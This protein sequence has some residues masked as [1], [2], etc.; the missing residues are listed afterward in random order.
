MTPLGLPTPQDVHAAYQ[1]GEEAVLVQFSELIFLIQNLQ[2]RVSALEDQLG[3]NSRNSSKPPSSDG[4]NKPRPRSLRTKSGKKSG[5]QPGHQGH[6]LKAV[7]QPDHVVIHPVRDCGQCG[8]SLDDIA[9]SA[10]EPRQVF[11]LPPVRVE[12]TEHRGEIKRCPCC[13][14]S[15]KAEFPS[16]VTQPVQY[17]P[18][19]KS[20]AVYL[21]QYQF[22]PLQRTKEIFSDLYGHGV[23]ESTIVRAT[24]EMTEC[25]RPV[26]EKVKAQLTEGEPVVHFD[27]SGLRVSGKL[28]W[29]HSA[30]TEQLTYYAVHSKRGCEAIDAIGILPKLKGRAVHD[31]WRSYFKYCEVSHSLCNAHHLRELDFIQERYEQDWAEEMTD[32]LLEIKGEVDEARPVKD[33]LDG[34]QVSE[35]EFR[36]D[37]LIEEGLK[38]NPPPVIAEDQ[39][40]KRGRV[41]QSPPKNLLDR[42]LAHKQEVLAFM[43]DFKVPFDNNQAERDIRMV[44]LKQKVSGCFRSQ[45]GAERFCEVRSYISTARKNGQPVLGAL[46]AALSG[47]PFVPALLLSG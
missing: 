20:Q 9:P 19:L 33:Q 11:E 38:A 2:E 4:L 8:A 35:F 13:G 1:Q 32:L 41:K 16:D 10:Y 26:N 3:K 6:T 14:Q 12:V 7:S 44:K 30:S 23:G 39:P 24:E 34:E 17:G 25:V 43:Y 36:Y 40:K 15:N 46:K 42:L 45:G 5:G 22:I 47:A 18:V 31:H 37:R 21:N 29:L 28:Q 27:E